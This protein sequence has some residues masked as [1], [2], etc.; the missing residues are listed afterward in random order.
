MRLEWL[1]NNAPAI[2]LA[3]NEP[4]RTHKRFAAR[5]RRY[6]ARVCRKIAFIAA[7]VIVVLWLCIA[8]S[9]DAEYGRALQ[10]PPSPMK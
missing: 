6:A 10:R 7:G 9:I 8:L 1:W 4:S 3:A 5:T 2:A